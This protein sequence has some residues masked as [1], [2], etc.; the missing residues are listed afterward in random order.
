[1]LEYALV[2]GLIVVAAI[3]TISS[4]GSKIL[5]DWNSLNSSL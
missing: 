1:V 2:A 5:A 4:V 3:A